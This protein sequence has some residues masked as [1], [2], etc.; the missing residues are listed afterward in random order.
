MFFFQS[1]QNQIADLQEKNSNLFAELRNC[2]DRLSAVEEEN[3]SLRERIKTLTNSNLANS[4][5]ANS[6][7]ANSN[8]ANLDSPKCFEK[9]SAD[10]LRLEK[11]LQKYKNKSA[12][13]QSELDSKDDRIEELQTELRKTTEDL[14]DVRQ[15]ESFLFRNFEALRESYANVQASERRQFE[16]LSEL[17][18]EFDALTQD[19]A[20]VDGWIR[21]HVN[22]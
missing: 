1:L 6:N 16:L 18:R 4:N 13:L 21:M 15:K 7:L 22:E 5:L 3:R 20:V 2:G 12:R 11:Q 17:Q 19:A 8:D 9:S 14:E 10:L